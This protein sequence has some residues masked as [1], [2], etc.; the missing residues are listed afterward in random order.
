MCEPAQALTAATWPN[1]VLPKGV[2]LRQLWSN[3]HVGNEGF[4]LAQ[5]CRN[6][7]VF[8]TPQSSD[9]RLGEFVRVNFTA[10]SLAV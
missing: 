10:R 9:A 8:D 2:I 1:A 3:S 6:K 4:S 5:R 7:A